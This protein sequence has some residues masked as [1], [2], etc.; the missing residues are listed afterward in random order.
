MLDEA[1]RH[2]VIRYIAGAPG[3]DWLFRWKGVGERLKLC[4]LADADHASHDESR[5]S[6]SCSEEFLGS[7]LL[8]Q[9]VVRETCVAISSAGSEFH[10]L[11]LCAARLLFTRSLVSVY[12]TWKDQQPTRTLQHRGG[13]PNRKGV[14][15]LKFRSEV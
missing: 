5:R 8:D 15:K 7:H 4:G 11:T 9:E 2:R 1:R 10:D 12:H 13:V 3:V 6:E 14:G